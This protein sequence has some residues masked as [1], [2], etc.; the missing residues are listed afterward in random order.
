VEIKELVLGGHTGEGL[1][2]S[3]LYLLS[4]VGNEEVR[5]KRIYRRESS[6]F[7]DRFDIEGRLFSVESTCFG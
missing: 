6:D 4:S 1:G 5:R 2:T 7:K 3:K